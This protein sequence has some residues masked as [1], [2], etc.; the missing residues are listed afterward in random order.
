MFLPPLQ[1]YNSDEKFQFSF[2]DELSE[3]FDDTNVENDISM[4]YPNGGELLNEQLKEAEISQE[5][6]EQNVPDGS[7]KNGI[8]C[9]HSRNRAVI[10]TLASINWKID[11]EAVQC[12]CSNLSSR[13][14]LYDETR[15]KFSGGTGTDDLTFSRI[16]GNI[17]DEIGAFRSSDRNRSGGFQF[18]DSFLV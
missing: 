18:R 13:G 8:E 16:R 11:D 15:P 7:R 3:Q 10:Q 12:A 9:N 17:R 2:E 6:R 14:H 5:L 1:R 4:K